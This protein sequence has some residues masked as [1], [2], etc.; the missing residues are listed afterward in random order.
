MKSFNLRYINDKG[1]ILEA[2]RIEIGYYKIKFPE[3]GIEQTITRPGLKK[4][5]FKPC[6]E[7]HA[8]GVKSS[9]GVKDFMFLNTKDTP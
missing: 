4:L 5:G 9:R 7:N 3:T 6:K 2:R 1:E 8:A